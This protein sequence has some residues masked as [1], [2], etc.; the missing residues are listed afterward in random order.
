M[1]LSL[2]GC[3]RRHFLAAAALSGAA[4]VVGTS[5]G[6]AAGDSRDVVRNPYAEI[7]W[8]SV[9]QVGSGTHIHCRSQ[10]ALEILYRRGLRH[11]AISNYYPSVPCTV[12]EVV[13]QYQVEQAFGTT[14][15][16]GYSHETFRWN[17]IIADPDTGWLSELPAERQAAL[18]F[19]TGPRIFAE[20]PDDVIFCPNAEHH[21]VTDS[22]L[23]FNA[24][25]SR[26]ASGT[27]D[28]R[29]GYQLDKHGYCMGVGL[30]WKEAFGRVWDGL[31]CEDGGGVTIN[32]PVWSG[33]TVQK[34]MEFLDF[35]P[36]VLGI[37]IWNHTCE[38]LNGKGWALKQWDEVLATG[39]RCFGF[40]VS[41]HVHSN[42]P[43]FQGYNIL[44]INKEV[45]ADQV[46]N[47]CLQAYRQGRFYCTL[48]GEVRFEDLRVSDRQVSIKTNHRCALRII[49][50]AGVVATGEG[51]DLEWACPM[52]LAERMRHRYV[53]V[54][55][56]QLDGKD[57]TF[58]QP[59]WLS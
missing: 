18:P 12:D 32:H 15:K 53:R 14:K 7:D 39:R 19:K 40:A 55:A 57:Q 29:N 10:R 56:K 47:A 20:V 33:L 2:N 44:L 26:F 36:R 9:R 49:S 11:L 23:H 42:D 34:I 25:G 6:E 45:A 21:S 16:A 22:G 30:P 24:V 37:E 43:E 5:T 50:A 54:E 1:S 38:Q 52:E 8:S 46:A 51:T 28:V 4:F 58:S 48:L 13:G 27:F 59:I 3:H 35:D 31:I 41:D 17:D